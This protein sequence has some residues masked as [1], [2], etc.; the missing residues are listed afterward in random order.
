MSN[1]QPL[2][3]S[4][5]FGRHEFIVLVL[6]QRTAAGHATHQVVLDD[7]YTYLWFSVV[8]SLRQLTDGQIGVDGA[9][10]FDELPVIHR[11]AI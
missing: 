11:L 6:R 8:W 5:G 7:E 4:F 3:A 10:D 1:L 2:A 9:H